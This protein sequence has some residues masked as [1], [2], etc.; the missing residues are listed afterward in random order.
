MEGLAITPDGKT[1]VGIMQANL[2]QDAK[3]MLRI[4]TID[5]ASGQTT[6][7]YAYQL[8]SGSGVSE[9]TAINDH[10]FLVDERDG[11][12]VG[13]DPGTGKKDLYVI[14]LNNAKDVSNIAKL[15]TSDPSVS[16][17]EFADVAGLL[18]AAGIPVPSK[19][20]GVT[21]GEDVTLN[22]Q[23]EHTLWVANDNDFVPG[24]S[25]P[26]QFFVF[27]FT[28]ADLPGYQVAAVPELSS[29]AMMVLGFV[30]VGLVMHRRK[31]IQIT[32]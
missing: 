18:S 15:S 16:K 7:E 4:V 8:T 30:G 10:Q 32:A 11:A 25:G 17:S 12:G 1:L 26:N 31:R 19:I 20:E 22:G 24:E 5:I 2:L 14:D 13:G 27:G 9:I 21:F 6:H 29:W 28:N 3:G 23:V